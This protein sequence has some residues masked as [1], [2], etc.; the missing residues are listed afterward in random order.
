MAEALRFIH[1]PIYETLPPAITNKFSNFNDTSKC[2]WKL[3]IPTMTIVPET[4]YISKS[5]VH[6][7]LHLYK[8]LPS[9]V[10]TWTLKNSI[11]LFMNIL[12]LTGTSKQ[13]HTNKNFNTLTGVRYN[14]QYGP[15]GTH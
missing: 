1:E 8:L 3:Y 10:R 11:S 15:F 9:T 14:V 7:S 4:E 13:S 5:I 6:H 12:D 2:T